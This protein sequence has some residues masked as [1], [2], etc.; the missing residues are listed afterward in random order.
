MKLHSLILLSTLLLTAARADDWK[1]DPGFTSLFNGKDL[2]GWCFRAKTDKKDPNPGA[3][4]ATH[5][6]KTEAADA[7]MAIRNARDV[8]TRRNEGVS[9]WVVRSS[10]V[11]ASSPGDKEALFDPAQSKVYRHPTF[12]PMPDEVKHI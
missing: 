8:Y 4:T 5:D 10:D 7:A 3:I 1:P 6:G 9:I 12:F 11:V 2:T